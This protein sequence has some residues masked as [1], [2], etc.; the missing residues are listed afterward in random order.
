MVFLLCYKTQDV[1]KKDFE[2][3][4][5]DIIV[6]TL[7]FRKNLALYLTYLFTYNLASLSGPNSARAREPN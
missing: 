5:E 7:I 1:S 4:E 3:S 2:G 6:N